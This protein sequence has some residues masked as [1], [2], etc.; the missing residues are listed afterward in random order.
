MILSLLLPCGARLAVWPY[1]NEYMYSIE[2]DAR[3]LSRGVSPTLRAALVRARH[4]LTEVLRES[5]RKG[6]AAIAKALS[7]AA[8]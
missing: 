4:A 2:T 6:Q 1:Q 8:H 3:V 5:E 7:D